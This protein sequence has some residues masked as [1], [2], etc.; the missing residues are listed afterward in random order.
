MCVCVCVSDFV[1]RAHASACTCTHIHARARSVRS[2]GHQIAGDE[3]QYPQDAQRLLAAGRL[4]LLL[5]RQIAV[6][7]GEELGSGAMGKSETRV[8]DDR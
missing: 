6:D 5:N 2:P 7:A 3:D 4:A 8:T 1:S